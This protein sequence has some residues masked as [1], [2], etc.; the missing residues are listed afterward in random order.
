MPPLFGGCPYIKLSKQV[1]TTIVQFAL[2]VPLSFSRQ[3]VKRKSKWI[4]LTPSK[5]AATPKPQITRA[6]V[7]KVPDFSQL[8]C[9][10]STSPFACLSC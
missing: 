7:T 1:S 8:S 6:I 9:R 5:R 2:P 4:S 3:P 10:V